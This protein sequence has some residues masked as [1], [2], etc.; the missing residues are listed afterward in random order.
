[1]KTSLLPFL[2]ALFFLLLNFNNGRAQTSKDSL[3]IIES[4]NNY[5][6]SFYLSKPELFKESVHIDLSKRTV[7]DY[8]KQGDYL[9]NASYEEMI[10]LAKIFNHSGKYSEN[11]K[12]EIFILDIQDNTASVRLNAAGWYDYMH[13]AKL[14][15]K[16]LIIN[17]L[18]G[19]SH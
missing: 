5:I 3:A 4:V 7:K 10:Y 15:D 17:V 12:A 13:L 11:S 2:L 16:W 6:Q 8:H 19:M 14:N 1:M 18:W 9:Q